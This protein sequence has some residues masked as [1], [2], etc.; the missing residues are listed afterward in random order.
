M[1]L[2][3]HQPAYSPWLGYFHKIGLS[4]TFVFFD[5]TQFEKNSFINRNKIKTANGPVWLTVP[6]K[7]K[8]HF[9]KPIK[10]IEIADQSWRK[11]HQ[12]ALEL[13]YKKAKYWNEFSQLIDSFY[14]KDFKYISD[15]CYE[16]LLM[17][18][19]ALGIDT[20]IV[21]ASDLS[22]Y[23]S[24]K[25]DLVLDICKGLKSN[26]YVSGGLGRDYID[27]DRFKRNNIGLY[28]QDY[29][30]PA[31][32]QL[33]GDFVPYMSLWDLLLN[34]GLNSRKIIFQDNITKEDLKNNGKK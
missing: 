28:F 4:D 33:W 30:H 27:A 24:K 3:I 29:K 17:F 6:V 8:D 12:K 13:N 25:N 18:N 31:Y 5:T 21:K 2:S 34:E 10:D 14:K 32:N 23:E 16:Q 26:L 22:K 9:D 1:I 19:A 20:K 7:L 15:L 11:K